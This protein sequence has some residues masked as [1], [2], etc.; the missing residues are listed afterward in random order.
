[1]RAT[2]TMFM[3]QMFQSNKGMNHEQHQARNPQSHQNNLDITKFKPYTRFKNAKLPQ[4]DCEVQRAW[5]LSV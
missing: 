5:N 3:F 4:I 1:M 2:A